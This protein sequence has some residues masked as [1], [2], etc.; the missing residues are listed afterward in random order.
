MVF[1]STRWFFITLVV[2]APVLLSVR[3]GRDKLAASLSDR[4]RLLLPGSN[5]FTDASLR[6]SSADPPTYSLIVQVATEADVKLTVNYANRKRKPFLA[7]SG[8]H[9]TTSLV[10]G[11]KNGIG[12]H[13]SQM[14]NTP[15]VDDGQAVLIEGGVL[16]GDLTATTGCDCVGFIAPILG[17]GHGYNQGR[18]G[19]ATDQLL[20]AR[21]V[22]TNGTAINI[23]QE[24]NPDLFWAIRGAGHNFGIMTRAKL[25]KYDVEPGQHQWAASGFILSY[26]KLEA[27]YAIAND[28][29]KDPN[30][31]PIIIAW[32]YFQGA[33]IPSDLTAPLHALA[34]ISVDSSVTD[35]AGANAHLLANKEGV[36]CAKG[37]TRKM[38]PIGVQEYDIAAIRQAFEIFGSVPPAFRNSVMFTEGY[39]TNRVKEIDSDSTAYSDRAGEF[40]LSPLLTYSPN[41][42]LDVV[43]DDYDGRIRDALLGGDR[44]KLVAYVNYA[45]EDETMQGMYGYEPWRLEKLR[46]LKKE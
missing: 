37:F 22:L 46:R 9:E 29:A 18:Y 28:W 5:E 6:W 21:I 40:L 12:I 2:L 27:L 24:D 23:S 39:P 7:I 44:S 20:S 30:K 31:S 38:V 41:A 16:N 26:D 17:G 13:L 34:P 15:I 35:I 43:A 4:A 11:L 19:K 3:P 36:A 42:S 10:G 1:P 8:G 33:S 32:L 25:R 14:N 45:R